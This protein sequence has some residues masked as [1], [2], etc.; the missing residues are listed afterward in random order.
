MSAV[1]GRAE[2]VVV[3]LGE[4]ADGNEIVMIEILRRSQKLVRV[5]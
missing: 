3:W 1:Y 4:H 5:G 2:R